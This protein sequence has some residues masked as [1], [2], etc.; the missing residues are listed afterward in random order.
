M[1]SREELLSRPALPTATVDLKEFGGSVKVRALYGNEK[2]EFS[3][4]LKDK[5]GD[6]L[7]KACTV[8]F[9][10]LGDDGQRLFTNE[11]VATILSAWPDS[12]LDAVWEKVAPL[13]G[14]GE[15]GI[16]AAEKN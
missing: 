6:G 7:L 11:D 10:A 1:L 16:E 3:A 12:A 9:F 4:L 13:V 2:D 8:A 15:K 14:Y 5:K